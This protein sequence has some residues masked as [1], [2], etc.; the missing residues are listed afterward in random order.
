MKK[1]IL[2]FFLIFISTGLKSKIIDCRVVIES[3]EK[4]YKIPNKL[5][6]AISLTESGR[7]VNG[8][9]V[10]WPWS[11]NVS[12]ESF[13]FENKEKTENFLRK[14]LSENNKNID[15]GC[16]QINYRYHN[17]SFKDLQSFVDPEQ[18]IDWAANF[19]R[20]LFVRHNSWNMA[21]SRYHSS[22]PKRMRSYLKKVKKNWDKER[23]NK[24]IFLKAK[25]LKN[26]ELFYNKYKNK[27]ENFKSLLQES[28]L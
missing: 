12:G 8:N 22:N 18:N 15:I 16:M 9:F 1:L 24:V 14:K 20:N 27:I 13:Y 17:K 7:T 25:P 28:S 2:T 6:S 4:K 21:I 10:A 3:A 19:L 26:S 23:Q 5:L 11:V